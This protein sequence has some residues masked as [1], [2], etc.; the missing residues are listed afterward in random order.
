[1]NNYFL[2]KARAGKVFHAHNTTVGA[3]TVLSA[4]CT[5]LILENPYGSGIDC[6]VESM[7][8]VG[9]TLT[10][11]AEIGIAVSPAVSTVLSSSTTAMKTFNGKLNG[12]TT[13]IG[14][15]LVYSIATLSGTPIWFESLAS[16][17]DTGAVEGAE[18]FYRN[19]EGTLVVP[20]G[21]YVAF[22]TLTAARTG[23]CSITWA[24]DAV[25][26]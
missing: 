23:L 18:A 19:F 17:R 10:T 16:C 4:T 20:P 5:G 13:H 9:S 7:S 24:E 6:I 25:I 22:S 14:R 26:A 12:D 3:V 21:M 15:A 1:M 11:I 2:E 8:F